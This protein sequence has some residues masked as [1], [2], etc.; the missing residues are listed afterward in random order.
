MLVAMTDESFNSSDRFIVKD[1]DSATK[2]FASPVMPNNNRFY[3]VGSVTSPSR[4]VVDGLDNVRQVITSPATRKADTSFRFRKVSNIDEMDS[5]FEELANLSILDVTT[6]SSISAEPQNS[7]SEPTLPNLNKFKRAIESKSNKFFDDCVGENPRFILNTS[8]DGPTILQGSQRHNVLHVACMSG[9]LH[10]VERIFELLDSKE[11][12]FKS[13]GKIDDITWLTGHL[14]DSFI[15]TPDKNANNTP[16]HF[17]AKNGHLEIVKKLLSHRVCQISP[18]NSFGKSPKD[19]VCESFKG[20]AEE[21]AKKKAEI[22]KL[23]YWLNKEI[24]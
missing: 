10:V 14:L 12:L 5:F 2:I 9:N 15:N 23:F 3:A 8:I 24:D 13:Y 4:Y 17:A 16:L 11:F 6:A 1:S 20:N 18:L 22:T 19:L 21:R 7:Y